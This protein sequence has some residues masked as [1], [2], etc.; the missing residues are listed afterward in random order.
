[1]DTELQEVLIRGK[2]GVLPEDLQQMQVVDVEF[3][4]DLIDLHPIINVELHQCAGSVHHIAVTV[5]GVRGNLG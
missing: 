5:T 2:P 1:M 4:G 3:R